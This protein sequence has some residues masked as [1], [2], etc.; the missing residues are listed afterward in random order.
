MGIGSIS[1]EEKFREQ[2]LK[3]TE[4]AGFGDIR[5]FRS[6]IGIEGRL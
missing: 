1:P 3:G 4:I 2:S 6:K 5:P